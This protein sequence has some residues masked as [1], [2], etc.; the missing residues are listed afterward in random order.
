MVYML[1]FVVLVSSFFLPERRSLE[2]FTLGFMIQ[3]CFWVFSS[4]SLVCLYF[5]YEAS[6][7]PILY[8]ILKWGSYPERS[9][10]AFMLL[11]YTVVFTLPFI[12]VLFYVFFSFGTFNLL[13]VSFFSRNFSQSL[14]VAFIIFL[15]FAVK[16]P[17]YGL[18]F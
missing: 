2:C 5:F 15:A 18:H 16:L 1:F 10:R 9:L 6:L 7:F 13:R 11:T 3:F 12:Y 14:L 8:I 4:V 17:I